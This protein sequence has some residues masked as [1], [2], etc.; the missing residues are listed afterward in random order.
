MS[1]APV[2]RWNAL[3]GS[4][5]MIRTFMTVTAALCL[6]LSAMSGMANAETVIYKERSIYRDITVFDSIGTRCMRFSRQN[7]TQQSC[8]SLSDPDALMFDCNKMMLGA[9]YLRPDPRKVLLIGLGGGTLASALIRLLPEAELSVVE[10]DPAIVQV[11][12]KYFNFRPTARVRV[13]EEDGRVFV[14]RALKRGEKY[15]LIMLDAFDEKYIPAHLMTRQFLQEV[16][17]ILTADG[18]LAANTFNFSELYH[19]ESVTY[20]SV[21]GQFFNLKKNFSNSRVILTRKDGLPSRDSLKEN[22]RI[23]DM[24]LRPLGVEASW[25]LSLFSTE[26]DWDDSA[27]VLTDQFSPFLSS[28]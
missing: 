23:L 24:K 5:L 27:R 25:L 13:A 20:E 26:R 28:F 2:W 3:S 15:D 4:G 12:R 18:V 19:N 11:A 14:K 6:F 8:I 17:K 21:Y 10:I 7:N 1:F 9:L 22:A 16:R